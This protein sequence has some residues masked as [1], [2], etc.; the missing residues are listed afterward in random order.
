MFEVGELIKRK[1]VS[2]K[3]RAICIVV[4]N[5]GDN[6]TLYNNSTQTI[7]TVACVVVDNLYVKH[8]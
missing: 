8:P 5:T 6:Y 4:E 7:R 1:E 2:P 3:T